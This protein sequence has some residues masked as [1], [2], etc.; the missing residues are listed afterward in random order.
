MPCHIDTI[1]VLNAGSSSLKFTLYK[2]QGEQRLANGVV[3]R[4][5]S[6]SANMVY[7]R[8]DGPKTEKPVIARNH[9][10]AIQLVCEA[11]TNPETGVIKTLREIDAIG[12]RILHGAEIFREA[13]LMTEETLSKVRE[14]VPFGPLHMPA[15]IGGIEAC[16]TIFPGVP[17][18][19]VFDTAFH[20]TMPDCA[21]HYAIPEIYYQKYGFRKYGFHGT[22]HHFITDAAAEFLGKPV[23]EVNLVTC[24][25]G[26]GSSLAAIKNGKVLDTT[27]G[28]TPLAGV[29]MGT[30]SGDIDPAV[31]L[32]LVRKGMTADEIDN[33][34]NKQSGLL[35]VGGINSNDMRDIV[36]HAAAGYHGAQLALQMWAHRIVQYIGAYYTLV[37]GADAIV[38]TGGIGENSWQARDLVLSRLA[39]LGVD[40]DSEANRTLRGP[41]YL[42]KPESKTKVMVLPTDEELMLAR[43]TYQVV[44]QG[45]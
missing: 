45:C 20:Q 5:A 24:H 13:T 37:G 3:E 10:D 34:L 30:R 16:Q 22:S 9:S 35:G 12:H 23:D 7:R 11:L 1:L 15:N 28:L 19:G 14:L 36:E 25:L 44:T 27:M 8:G 43:E 38:L 41:C 33:L 31:V 40:Y 2:I 18:V 32:E 42:T 21:S 29:V 39:C 4:I 26:N 17:S 6:G